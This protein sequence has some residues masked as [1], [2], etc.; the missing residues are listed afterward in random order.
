M[1]NRAEY[2]RAFAVVRGVIHD[3]DP[4]SLIRG[5]APADEWDS[6]IASLVDQIP[7]IHSPD[8]AID[9]VSRVFSAAFEPEG[10]APADC[11]DIGHRLYSALTASG[12]LK[13]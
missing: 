10:F 5:G 3:W 11:T 1:Q 13:G 4:Y 9:A 2:D 6:E 12:V 8:D 7:R